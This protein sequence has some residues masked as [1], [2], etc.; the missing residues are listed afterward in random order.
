MSRTS[1]DIAHGFRC[2]DRQ[3]AELAHQCDTTGVVLLVNGD[4]YMCASV[5][6]SS[7]F[8]DSPNG[9]VELTLGQRRKPRIGSGIQDPVVATGTIA[10]MLLV[11]TDGLCMT[12]AAVFASLKDGREDEHLAN[13]ATM[14][15]D[16][17]ARQGL[18]DDLAVVVV[19]R[20]A[21]ERIESA[22]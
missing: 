9:V 16:C 13:L 19:E 14:V 6:D 10:G 4:H 7:A 8:M 17:A 11:A 5:G 2:T 18:M 1:A 22:Q 3:I 21:P 15:T 12:P 20:H